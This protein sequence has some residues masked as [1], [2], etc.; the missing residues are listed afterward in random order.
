MPVMQDGDKCVALPIVEIVSENT[1]YDFE[2]KYTVGMSHH[3]IPARIPESAA[4][5]IEE[6]AVS[7]YKTLHCK[8]VARIDFFID[9]NNNPYVIEINTIPGMTKTSLVPDSAAAVG[10]SFGDLAE[11]IINQPFI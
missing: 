1:F 3:I 6:Y 7:A 4:K 8:G 5:K 9:E 10:L 11:K 2:S